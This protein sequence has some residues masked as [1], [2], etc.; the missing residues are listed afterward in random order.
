MKR[1]EIQKIAAIVAAATTL[2][3]TANT[4]HSAYAHSTLAG[5]GATIRNV[6]K[7]QI[8]LQLYPKFPSEGQNVTLHFTVLDRNNLNVNGVYA[9]MVMK[10]KGEI[11]GQVPYRFYELGDISM[12][13]KFDDNEDYVATLLT[14]VN[15]DPKYMASPLTADFDIPVGQTTIMGPSE[16]LIMV[17]PFT[18]AL[19][20]GIIFLFKKRK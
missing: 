16:L 17:V 11:D 7:Y 5:S 12:H 15:G 1:T 19:A 10:E 9:A 3:T 18:A 20:A 13:Y 4:L 8:A 14:R 2:F 6:A